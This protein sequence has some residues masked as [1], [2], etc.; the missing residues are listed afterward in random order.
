MKDSAPAPAASRTA[1]VAVFISIL[2]MVVV[3]I[4]RRKQKPESVWGKNVYLHIF[5]YSILAYRVIMIV[6]V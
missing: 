6:H 4:S 2:V 3:L 1:I 5:F